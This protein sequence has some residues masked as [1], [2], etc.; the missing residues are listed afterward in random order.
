M[1]QITTPFNGIQRNVPG[2]SV[3]DGACNE[4]I[5]LRHKDGVLKPVGDKQYLYSINPDLKNII[6]HSVANTRN[7]IAYNPVNGNIVSW[8]D[9]PSLQTFLANIGLNKDISIHPIGTTLVVINRT[10]NKLQYFQNNNGQY[11][12][13]ELPELPVITF[14]NTPSLG[15]DGK[16]ITGDAEWMNTLSVTERWLAGKS[17]IDKNWGDWEK[18]GYCE[19]YMLFTYC[20][21]LVDESYVFPSLPQLVYAGNPGF[22]RIVSDNMV[23]IAVTY[24]AGDFAVYYTAGKISYAIKPV[25]TDFAK[26]KDLIKGIS[27]FVTYPEHFI[28]HAKVEEVVSGSDHLKAYINEE[29]SYENLI[30]KD[31]YY[32]VETISIER[33]NEISL[34]TV[35]T[36]LKLEVSKLKTSDV[37]PVDSFTHHKMVSKASFVY[38]SRLCLANT[39][40]LLF[41]GYSPLSVF[42]TATLNGSYMLEWELKTPDGTKM[43]RSTTFNIP[44]GSNW[45]SYITYPDRRAIKCR[46]LY[47]VGVWMTVFEYDLTPHNLHNFSYAIVK[48][49]AESYP[50]TPNHNPLPF[51]LP[52]NPGTL[53]NNIVNNIL[54]DKNRV[55]ISDP[56]NPFIFPAKNSYQVGISEALDLTSNSDPISQGQFGQYPLLVFCRD[57]VW[58]L[59]ISTGEAYISNISPFNGEILNRTGVIFNNGDFLTFID[60]DFNVKIMFGREAIK[61]SDP[62]LY[63]KDTDLNSLPNFLSATNHAQ[64]CRVAPYLCQVSGK[65]YIKGA[66][67]GY[68]KDEKE[69]ILSNPAYPYSFVYS[70][71]KKS[72]YKAAISF[73]AF[74]NDYPNLLGVSSAVD[75]E[76]AVSIVN[77]E[78]TEI[79]RQ[80][81]ISYPLDRQFYI[82]TMPIKFSIDALK[83]IERIKLIC[84]VQTG[85]DTYVSFLIYGSVDGVQ[86]HYLAGKQATG[87][88]ANILTQIK[89]LSCKYFKVIISGT[90][91]ANSTITT[92]ISEV[93]QKHGN[94]LR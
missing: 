31:L 40:S 49:S 53:N 33:V 84:E 34:K 61:I 70:V 26:Y 44:A 82:E 39:S 68:N 32:K 50:V 5:N 2:N 46:L 91:Y 43:V 86:Y 13:V 63:A 35:P 28:R 56:G 3:Q 74:I 36:E 81:G 92:M 72:W 15:A 22:L 77:D 71:E 64:T 57:G 65:D 24:L 41:N 54:I 52:A 9:N 8:S 69:I 10:D 21:E 67:I 12:F 37:L 93:E 85:G 83:Q 45:P 60:S 17:F 51:S 89:G 18:A 19:G 79:V 38:N 14:S 55:Q 78:V 76:C 4:L 48:N 20:Y 94:K 30:N 47:N 29:T 16:H 75:N 87:R 25:G 66:I 88:F 11:T 42:P 80:Y 1:T 73:K 6:T 23:N 7:M 90:V 59:Q 62:I 58:A 27:I